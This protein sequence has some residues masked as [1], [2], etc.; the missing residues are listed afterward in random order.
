MLIL[1]IMIYIVAGVFVGTGFYK[2]YA[3]SNPENPFSDDYVN[4]YVG[5]D[6]YNY[7]INT[8]FANAY[9]T[10]ALILTVLASLFVL[11]HFYIK[12]QGRRK[13]K[14]KLSLDNTNTEEGEKNIGE[15]I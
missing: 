9:F 10:L 11:V 13:A 7:I 3:Y 1:A 14:E 8:G 15:A 6:A 12:E 5:G 2:L 4:V